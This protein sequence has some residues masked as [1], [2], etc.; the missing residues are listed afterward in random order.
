VSLLKKQ[1]QRT[2]KK[3]NL[4]FNPCDQIARVIFF[5]SK[6]LLNYYF[7][8][9]KCLFSLL[10]ALAS[11]H[12]CYS[13]IR[14]S[15][16]V[17]TENQIYTIKASDILVVDTL[18][19]RDSSTIVLAHEK[20]DNFMHGK[21]IVIGNGCKI[22][23]RGEDG[24]PGKNGLKGITGNGPCRDGLNGRGATG[25][26]HG[27]D[28]INLFIYCSDIKINGHLTIDLNGGD[29]G[30]GGHGGEGGGG[31]PGTRV[32]TGGN[33]GIGGNGSSG[34][35][36]G[37]GGNLLI[38]CKDC[39]DLRA[40]VHR[41]ITVKSFGG[42]AGVGGEGGP[43]GMPGLNPSGNSAMDG[44]RGARGKSGANGVAGKSGAINFER[45]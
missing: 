23:G 42:N 11:I 8:E 33:G 40:W 19:M 29:G 43:G 13:Q 32:C 6:T 39:P 20:K 21:H 1:R 37:N 5:M 28:G 24:A 25:G 15:K 27:E 14:L 26:M 17:I 10:L 9:M 38:D 2:N 3:P 34:G 18:I 7:Y 36:G 35:N 31:S 45:N 16:L 44:Q 22:I 12:S 41:T 30:D 4:T